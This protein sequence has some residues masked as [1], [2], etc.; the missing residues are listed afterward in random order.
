MDPDLI[1]RIVEAALLAAPQP[2]T[3]AQLAAL[4]PEAV[5]VRRAG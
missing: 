2:Q 4:F 1:K 3:L 5:A